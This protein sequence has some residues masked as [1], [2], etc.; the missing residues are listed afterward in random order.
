MWNITAAWASALF[1]VYG[2][3]CVGYAI[4]KNS[5]EAAGIGTC[6]MITGM[7]FLIVTTP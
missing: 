2:A 1:F 3:G 7:I 5:G 6:L 4:G